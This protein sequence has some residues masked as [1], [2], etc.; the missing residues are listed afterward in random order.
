MTAAVHNVTFDSDDPYELARFWS[1]VLGLPLDDAAKPGDGE[2]YLIPAQGHS[3]FLFVK[4]P[5]GKTAKNR[6]HLDLTHDTT[7]DGEVDRILALGATI[8]QDHRRPNGT[9]WAYMADPEGNEFCVERNAA[10]RA[11]TGDGPNDD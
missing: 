4:V 6:M 8:V 3:G 7:R 1:G 10:E 2:V 11:A 5:E 9:G